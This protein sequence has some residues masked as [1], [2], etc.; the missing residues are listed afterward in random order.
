MIDF[1]LSQLRQNEILGGLI[2]GS[3]FGFLLYLVR[4]IPGAVWDFID[5]RLT[6]S[7][8]V[9]NDDSSFERVNEW[10]ASLDY[11]KECR[12]LRLTAA[13]DSQLG[14]QRETL[15]P[16]LGKH[17]I[18]YRGRPVLVERSLPD[19][20]GIGGWKR[21]EDIH[22]RTFGSSPAVLHDLIKSIGEARKRS[23]EKT[24]EVFLY[25]NRWRI[26]CRKAKRDLS[27][28]VLP[29]TQKQELI[30]DV[31]RFL[32]SRQWYADRGVPY[33]RGYLFE[34]PP[35]CGKTTFAMVL[36]GHFARPIYAL[37]LGSIG[38]DD[39]LIDAVC[40]V[41]EHGILLIEDIDAAEVGQRKAGKAQLESATPTME[42]PKEAI[43]Q[44]TLSG[45]LNV[46]DG[47]FARDGRILIM[48]TNHPEKVDAALLR[49]G[50][51]DRREHIG[52]IGRGDIERMAARFLGSADAAHVFADE[53]DLKDKMAP[54]AVQE[55]LLR[56]RQVMA[57]AAE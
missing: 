55:L 20:G 3:F 7:L 11:A 24:I 56:N 15:A 1:I 36:A 9:F 10:L 16:G 34:G 22:I 46:L 45:L 52:L 21:L 33:R 41:P 25:R 8:T 32:A 30:A 17:L 38:N 4:G 37:N 29:G 6:C 40:D 31:E 13:Y 53:L 35:G 51:A 23:H 48:T 57:E 42:A 43:K 26:A 12:R 18:W 47:V 2:G 27:T 19:K 5:W 39:E 49:P 28:L 44:V 14:E 54:A 50:R